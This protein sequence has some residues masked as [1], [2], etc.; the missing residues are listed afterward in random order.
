MPTG[1][2]EGSGSGC[3]SDKEVGGE[4]SLVVKHLEEVAGGLIDLSIAQ[5]TKTN[6]L[7]YQA[8]GNICIFVWRQF[9]PCYHNRNVLHVYSWRI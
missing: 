1:Q 7:I 9:Y 3:K 6:K 2:S 8:R 4:Q 5:S